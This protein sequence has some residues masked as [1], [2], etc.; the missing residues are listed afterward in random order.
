VGPVAHRRGVALITEALPEGP[1]G[2]YQLQAAIAAVHDEA[3][4]IDATDWPQILGLYELLEQVDPNPIVTL[5]RTIAVAMVHGPAAALDLLATLGSDVRLARHHRLFATRAHLLELAGD[6][7]AAAAGHREAA[8]RATSLPER[9]QLTIRAAE[10]EDQT[11][12]PP[13]RS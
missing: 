5:N 1:V 6:P 2:P 4:H 9:R 13:A 12:Q 7:A 3:D 11:R 10:I 8:R